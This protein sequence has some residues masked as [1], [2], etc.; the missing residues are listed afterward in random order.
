MK[1]AKHISRTTDK[2]IYVID[3]FKK[4][5]LYVS[6][7][8]LFLCGHTAEEVKEMGYM[9]YINN[10]PEEEQEMLTEINRAGFEFI[11]KIPAN[12]RINYTI[13]YD[14]HIMKGKKKTLVNQ[15][16]T[17]LLLT[18]EGKTWIAVCVV[19]LST[20]NKPGHI[21]IRKTNQ[22]LFWKY[23]IEKHRWKEE[24]GLSLNDR[25]KE[26]LS[27]SAQ[28]YTMNE[29][30]DKLFLSIDTIKF[31]KRTLFKKLDVK[32]IIEA[33]TFASNYKLL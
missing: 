24:A 6:D 13:S 1:K 3:Y 28:G 9:F 18:E 32:N 17:S 20:H 2:S 12:D 26:I 5:F 29:I 8:P 11:N 27:L 10:V 21:E 33:I 15:K 25:E 4:S 23:S 16:L 19:S 30:A 14:F 31:H 7:N 22:P